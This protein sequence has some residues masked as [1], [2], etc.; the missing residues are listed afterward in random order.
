MPIYTVTD[1]SETTTWTPTQETSATGELPVVSFPEPPNTYTVLKGQWQN[2][3]LTPFRT[4]GLQTDLARSKTAAF[5]IYFQPDE[6][7]N[8]VV[9]ALINMPGGPDASAVPWFEMVAGMGGN[10]TQYGV[11]VTAE[12]DRAWPDFTLAARENT[13]IH[14]QNMWVMNLLTGPTTVAIDQSGDIGVLA[15]T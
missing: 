14:A 8:A 10:G 5:F 3:Q 9:A 13:D 4:R 11:L 7:E 2:F 1:P 15:D 6:S 12:D